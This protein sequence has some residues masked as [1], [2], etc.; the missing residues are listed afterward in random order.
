MLST[1]VLSF[2]EKYV[3]KNMNN[4]LLFAFTKKIRTTEKT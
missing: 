4:V 3:K 1:S 2:N